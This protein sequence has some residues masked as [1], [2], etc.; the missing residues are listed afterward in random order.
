MQK[1]GTFF[2]YKN[3]TLAKSRDLTKVGPLMGHQK[4]QEKANHNVTK[5]IKITSN[6]HSRKERW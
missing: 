5:K 6:C 4:G 3:Q 1:E 2:S